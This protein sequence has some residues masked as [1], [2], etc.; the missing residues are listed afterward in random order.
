[1]HL[2]VGFLHSG[3]TVDYQKDQR[4]FWSDGKT[5]KIWSVAADGSDLATVLS[6]SCESYL[7]CGK[8]NVLRMAYR[9]N[10]PK[11][12]LYFSTRV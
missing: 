11:A 1:M 7:L 4:V 8:H 2:M 9:Y 5:N 12:I 6:S 10:M 3:L